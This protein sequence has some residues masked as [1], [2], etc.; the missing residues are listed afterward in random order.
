MTQ[1]TSN[2]CSISQWAAVEALTGPQ[3]SVGAMVE[4]FSRSRQQFVAGLQQLGF[5]CEWPEGAFYAY[6]RIP[7]NA[8][9]TPGDSAAYAN[10]LLDEKH[11]AAVAGSGFFDEGY[12]RMSYAASTTVLEEVLERMRGFRQ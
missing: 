4:E 9:G 12:L 2:P 3:E 10:R 5:R 1:T 6:P 7:D 8:D 11:V